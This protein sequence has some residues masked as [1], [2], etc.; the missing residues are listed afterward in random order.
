MSPFQCS[1]GYQPPLFPTQEPEAA[2][3]SAL[4][5]VRRCRRTWKRAKVGLAWASRRTKAAVDRHRTPAPRYVRGQRVWLFTKDLPLRVASRK[6]VRRF[7]GPYRI[8]KVWSPA[9]VRLKLLPTLGQVH[10]VF[11][12]S[13]VK[14]VLYS[15]LVPSAPAL[16]L[17]DGSPVYTMRKL[18]YVRRRGRGFQFL[19]D[20]EGYDPEER[21]W[22]PAQDILDRTL[23]EDF[24]RRR[25]EPLP[26]APGGA[27]RRGG[28]VMSPG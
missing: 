1:V 7:I 4:A 16:H 8:T 21:S 27:R 11:H 15:P 10:P 18:L 12:V 2:V 3:P 14:P 9:V 5:F 19:V 6:L 25:G 13:R 28:T 17:V 26:V 20:W 23:V 22:I 24:C